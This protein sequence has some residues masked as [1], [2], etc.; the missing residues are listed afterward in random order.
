[1]K[2]PVIYTYSIVYSSSE[3]FQDKT[4]YVTAI[5]EDESGK[6]FPAFLG[7]YPEGKAIV[8][9]QEVDFQGYDQNQKAVYTILHE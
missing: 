9:G 3:L 5:L 7:G 4:P 1:M 6:R 8:I 2:K